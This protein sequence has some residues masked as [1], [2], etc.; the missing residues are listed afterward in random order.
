M[1]VII[2]L[3]EYIIFFI[4]KYRMHDNFLYNFDSTRQFLMN[5]K[6]FKCIFHAFCGNLQRG[7]S[8]RVKDRKIIF[9]K[10][11]FYAQLL[12]CFIINRIIIKSIISNIFKNRS[13]RIIVTTYTSALESRFI[14]QFESGWQGIGLVGVWYDYVD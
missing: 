3:I 11:V 10:S 8:V 9:L 6:F 2:A 5:W 1:P 12:I 14:S 4:Y 13:R 7:F